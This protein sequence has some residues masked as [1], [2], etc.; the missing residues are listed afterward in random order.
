MQ[1]ARL[2]VTL[3][4]RDEAEI[5]SIQASLDALKA[6]VQR[7]LESDPTAG[8][9]CFNELASSLE[10]LDA[11]PSAA[12]VM[13]QALDFLVASLRRADRIAELEAGYGAL[14]GDED[15]DALV[16]VMRDRLPDRFRED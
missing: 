12:A 16:S 8:D 15:R 2:S 14:A 10:E 7:V 6:T 3:D 9:G 1:M 4:E 5:S 13:R 11:D